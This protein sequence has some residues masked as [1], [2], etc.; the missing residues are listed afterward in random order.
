MRTNIVLND[1]LIEKGMRCT[2]I[3]T[4]RELVEY[5]LSELIKRKERKE[6]LRLK[7]KLQWEGD[8][9]ELRGDRF[10]NTR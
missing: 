7:G 4:K 5:A 9:A 2:G 6:T 3:K 1:E 10:G 8:M